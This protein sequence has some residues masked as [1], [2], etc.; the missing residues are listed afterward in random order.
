MTIN[1][2]SLK[3]TQLSTYTITMVVDT[4]A[5]MSKFMQN[6]SKIMVKESSITML[7]K[8]MDISGFDSCL[9]N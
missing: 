7:V 9:T 2:Y 6:I 3:F 1:D 4:R 5:R 8:K